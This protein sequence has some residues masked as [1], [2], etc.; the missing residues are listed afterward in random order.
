MGGKAKQELHYNPFLHFWTCWFQQRLI[1][2]E[3]CIIFTRGSL[4][5]SLCLIY[6]FLLTQQYC[7][8]ATNLRWYTIVIYL[9]HKFGDSADLG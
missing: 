7:T 1:K 6:Q 5:K 9:A 2:F 4:Q 8:T 3:D